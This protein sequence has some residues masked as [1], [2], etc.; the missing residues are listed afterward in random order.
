MPGILLLERRDERQHGVHAGLVRA[1]QHAALLD[2]AQVGDGRRGLV[3]EPQ[4]P[5]RVL[6]E[7]FPRVGQRAVARRPVDELLARAVL[8]PAD[9]L[10]HRGL[11]AAELAGGAREAAFGGHH[12][13]DA[14]ILEGHGRETGPDDKFPD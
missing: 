6:E 3:D 14:E 2:V 8:E 11:R 4:E 13:E 7:H 9:R 5:R 1:D 12:G 10:A